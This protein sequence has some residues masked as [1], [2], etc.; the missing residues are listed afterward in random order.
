MHTN[1][2]SQ[3]LWLRKKKEKKKDL[4]NVCRTQPSLARGKPLLI[5]SK[6]RGIL[7][8]AIC[9]LHCVSL[10]ARRVTADA[11]TLTI[12]QPGRLDPATQFSPSHCS[13]TLF[14]FCLFVFLCFILPTFYVF[15]YALQKVV[16]SQ[17][18]YLCLSGLLLLNWSN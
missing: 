1:A 9:P 3:S 18:C 17:C 13:V 7:F 15:L 8:G 4:D 14:Y 11:W 10:E 2:Q 6:T 16:G 12:P 5:A